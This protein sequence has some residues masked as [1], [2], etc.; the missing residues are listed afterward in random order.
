MS[1]LTPTSQVFGAVGSSRASVIT[2]WARKLN[3]RVIVICPTEDLAE[4][5]GRDLECFSKI[6]SENPLPVL[7]LPSWEHTPYSSV[8][9][10]I[11]TRQRRISALSFLLDTHTPGVLISSISSA[12]Q[13]TLPKKSFLD[14]TV[15]LETGK[16]VGSREN[17]ILRLQESG[18]LRSDPIEDPGMFSVRGDIVDIFPPHLQKPLR[19]E[20]FDDVIEK[21]RVFDPAS[22]RTEGKNSLSRVAIHPARE[23]LLNPDTLPVLKDQIKIHADDLGIHRSLRD[24]LLS[25]IKDSIYPDHI[26]AWAPFIYSPSSTLLDYAADL[27]LAIDDPESCSEEMERFIEKQNKH[28]LQTAAE[29]VMPPVS[30]L[31]SWND[32]IKNRLARQSSLT[33]VRSETK[34]SKKLNIL[35]SSEHL[36]IGG[37]HPI[38]ETAPRL[39]Q[40]LREGF[41]V[42]VFC[43]T[44]SQLSRIRFLL[45]GRGLTCLSS[46]DEPLLSTPAVVVLGIGNLSSGFIDHE[47]G[48]VLLSDSELLGTKNN[49]RSLRSEPKKA[50]AAADWAGLQNLGDLTQGDYVVHVEHGIGHYLGLVRLNLLGAPSDYI[51]IE[52]AN[53]DKLYLP[54]YRLNVIQKYHGGSATASLDKLGGLL[55]EKT[56]QK[57]RDS[58]KKLAFDLVEL[59]A[60]RKLQ[61]A[62][63]YSPRD[64]EYREF[65]AKFAFTE[66][67][68]QLKA[69]DSAAADMEAGRIM[70]RL[71]C[72]DVGYGKTEIAIRAAFF[73]VQNGKQVAVLVP[74]TVLAQQH[75]E[76]FK[77]RFKDYPIQVA[78]VS[79]YK[80]AKEQKSTLQAVSA[81]TT[82]I[83]IGTHRLLSKDVSFKDL[84]LIIIDEE[85]RFGVEH[86]ERLKTLRMNTHVMT[87][88]ATP[89]PRTLHMALS[90]LR[91]ISLITTPPVDR[92]PIRTFVSKFNEETL[93]DAIE[94]E[95]ARGGQVF[96]VHNKV[97]DIYA[98]A[99]KIQGLVPQA[100]VVVGH[101]QMAE[102]QLEDA[103]F[104]FYKKEANVLVCTTIIES[105]LDV[106]SAN[107]IIINSAENYG[108]AQL[109]QLRGRVGRSDIRAYAYL[110][111]QSDSGMNESAK[112][113]LETI[114]RFVEL[115]SGFHIASHDLEIRGGGNLIG[116]E[117]SGQI[118]AVGFEL[119][120][121]LLDEAIQELQGQPKTQDLHSEPE[122]KGPFSAYLDEKYIPDI[123]QRLSFYRRLSGARE[124]PALLALESE[125]LD[126]YGA[127]PQEAQNLF[128]LIR[129]KNLLRKAG[130]DTLIV[131]PE[132]ISLIPGKQSRLDPVKTVALI[133]SH[134]KT[135]SATSDGKWVV[136]MP[137]RVINELYF[138]LESL[139][140]RLLTL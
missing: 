73:A 89:I 100:K 134:P 50:S 1:S 138:S 28:A 62:D 14:R 30:S 88:T 69:I 22:Q 8:A 47:N 65:E 36:P 123:H 68:D 43:E 84:G 25:M 125:L 82:D 71:I 60:K 48:Q 79:R 130:I 54:I 13:A 127:P 49:K 18:Y 87:L 66:T 104:S 110:F 101:G 29:L 16:S 11:R 128:W 52:Y 40:Y 95:L 78:S 136:V 98:L 41:K 115:G 20:L 23:V 12:M 74:T 102:G 33:L 121:E 42:F 126:R 15:S 70:D 21:I 76:S 135:Y 133:A 67:P 118:A 72:G 58:V 39:S 53:K 97:S 90:G 112:R 81:G 140:N 34:E 45:E 122:I 56:K 61:V 27:P 129:I 111:T 119:Y 3:Q 19:I 105:G 120:T 31:F 113:R 26:D 44:Q 6:D 77:N 132:K 38:E 93:R 139:L 83:I 9:L 85:H 103:M 46:V 7:I 63:P 51:Q 17:L 59:Y 137:S 35:R 37:A 117:Q 109:Y 10:S 114:Q 124:E 80:S 108:L 99:S 96:F 55:F 75:E 91:D 64:A 2:R 107:T 94:T 106:P 5:L 131:G 32:E 24:P 86:K 116:P 4:D 92:L 57:V